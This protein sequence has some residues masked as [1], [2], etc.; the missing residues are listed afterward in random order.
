MRHRR[1]LHIVFSDS[2]ILNM[3]LVHNLRHMPNVRTPG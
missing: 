3:S 2:R 1:S